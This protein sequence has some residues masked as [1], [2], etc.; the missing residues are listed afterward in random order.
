[1]WPATGVVVSKTRVY[2]SVP[3]G[4]S[5][6]GGDDG[7]TGR[8]VQEGPAV[9]HEDA[10]LELDHRGPGG[11]EL[12][13]EIVGRHVGLEHGAAGEHGHRGVAGLGPG[14]DRQVRLGDDDDSADAKRA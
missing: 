13:D 9:V 2:W 6:G 7:S 4:R 3:I 5:A 12:L 14:V 10:A 8:L 11:P 1:M